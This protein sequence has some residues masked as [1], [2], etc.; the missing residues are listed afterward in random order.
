MKT[1]LILL[2]S[3]DQLLLF[4]SGFK[5]IGNLSSDRWEIPEIGIVVENNDKAMVSIGQEIIKID[6]R[7]Y[8][9]TEVDTLT[10]DYSKAKNLLKWNPKYTFDELIDE[11]IKEDL[12]KFRPKR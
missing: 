1:S 10:G 8:R 9:P 5:I 11:M 3:N 7:Y 2:R 4:P 6:S 12:E